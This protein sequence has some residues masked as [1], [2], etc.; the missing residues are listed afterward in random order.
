M[1]SLNAREMRK[2][3]WRPEVFIRKLREGSVFE[4]NSAKKVTLLPPL[5]V[6]EILRNGSTTELNEL[7][8]S[9][10]NGEIY[11]LSDF[12]K[13]VEFG[14]KEGG[15]SL[16]KE[17]MALKQLRADINNKK[18]EIGKSTIPIKIGN[19]VYEVYDVQST[20][21]TPKSD[22][23]LVDI[24]GK[25]IVWISHKDG[26][27]VTH[28]QQWGGTSSRIEPQIASHKETQEFVNKLKSIFPKGLI[29]KSPSY[30]RRIKDEKLKMMSIYG[31]D[32]GKN[33]G[34]QNVTL[35]VQGNLSLRKI[36]NYYEINAQHYHVNGERITNEYEAVFMTRLSSD[37][38]DFGIKGLRLFIAPIGSRK[39]IEI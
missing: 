15:A 9:D 20:P 18:E 16:A 4:L 24:N 1:A 13:T 27:K 8:F 29:P 21:G 31:K 39:A 34:R 17:D 10:I 6:E 22:F 7:R 19:K 5:D 35:V 33:M 11:K 37:R 36:S 12:K 30:F 2:Y 28:F 38:G 23:H 14:G 32:F 26:T 25:E 3:D